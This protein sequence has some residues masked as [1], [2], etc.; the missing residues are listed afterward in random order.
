MHM[1]L[2]ER[3]DII[4]VHDLDTLYAGAYLAQREGAKLIY[5]S[6]ELYLEQG[7]IKE[8]PDWR[9]VM[10]EIESTC[11]HKADAL[12]SV[13][14]QI[15]QALVEKY[16]YGGPTL[17]MYNSFS[18]IIDVPSP[19]DRPVR[20]LF[21]GM[22][23]PERN[24]SELVSAMEGLRGHATLTLQGFGDLKEGLA[25]Q[26]KALDLEEV[27]FFV[28]PVPPEDIVSSITQ[29]DVGTLIW[30]PTSENL[31]LSAPNKLF[32]YMGAGLAL[33]ASSDLTFISSVID[34]YDNGFT[35]VFDSVESIT[36]AMR[37]ICEDPQLIAGKKGA[38]L[39]AAKDFSWHT[40][41]QE[42]VE[43]CAHL[44]KPGN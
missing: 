8:V 37:E 23:D 35:F 10:E 11:I 1:S 2:A 3:P 39:T 34:T 31:A 44:M 17:E 4:H 14:P 32:D 36:Q 33:V 18:P 29:Y 28:D 5:D 30:S 27:V 6:H 13:A 15:T 9:A 24:V 40:K 26:V 38:S 43:L 20:F 12:I 22:F 41:E 16:G 42:F 25:R 21:T 7:W 19:I